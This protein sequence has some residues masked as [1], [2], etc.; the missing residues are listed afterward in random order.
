M[1]RILSLSL[2]LIMVLSC[3]AV[4]ASCVGGQT[5]TTTTK[6]LVN[7]TNHVDEDGDFLCDTEGCGMPV[8]KAGNYTYNTYMSTFPTCWNPHTYR[9]ATNGEILGYTEVGFYTFDYNETRDGFVIVP[10]MAAQ[11]PVDVTAEYVGEQWEIDEDETARAWK[12][13]LRDDLRWENGDPIKATDFVES[14]KRLLDPRYINYRA[15]SL[16]EGDMSIYGAREY[17]YGGRTIKDGS[18][19]ISADFG[20]DEYVA[21]ADLSVDENGQYYSEN[22]KIWYTVKKAGN[23]STSNSL[24]DYVNAGYCTEEVTA[25]YAELV[26]AADGDGFVPVTADTLAVIMDVIANLHGC[27]NVEAYAAEAGD[28]AY[29]EWEEACYY[30]NYFD[31]YSWDNVGILATAENEVV[32]IINDPLEG[33]YLHYSLTGNLGLVHVPTYDACIKFDELTN[34]YSN[35]YGTSVDTFMAYGP[36]KLTTFIKDKQIVLETNPHWYGYFDASRAGQFMTTKVVYDWIND[37]STAMNAFLQGK[38]DGKGLDATNIDEYRGSDRLYYT[39]GASTWFIALN[40]SEAAANTWEESHPGYDKSILSYKEFRMAL[41]QSLNRTN[42]I[43]SLDPVGSIAYGLYN[44]MICSDPDKGVMYRDEEVAKDAVLAFWGIS[45]DDIGPDGLYATKDEA[46]ESITGYN[47]EMAKVLFDQAYDKAVA[48]GFYD[49]QETVQIAIGLPGTATF[50][51]DGFELLKNCWTDAVKGTKL[52]G[53]L[54]FVADSSETV[55]N[56]FSGALHSNAIDMLFGV[57][58]KGSALNPY[59]LITAYTNPAQ[60]YD[61]NWDT[62]TATM[63]VEINGVTYRASIYDWSY[64]INGKKAEIAEVG[65]DGELTGET[66]DYSCGSAD[67]DP[68]TRLYI[69]AAIEKAVLSQYNMIPTHNQASATLLGYQLEYGSQ[70]YVYGLGRGGIQYMTY[71]YTDEAWDEYV[72]A[73][74]GI[75]NY[76]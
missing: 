36:Y 59:S 2:A 44:S 49:G 14:A 23:W 33:F 63:D 53:K 6:P 32:I 50:Y 31:E 19:M 27:E 74:G 65:E 62:T 46:I 52:E 40:P 67:K 42:F 17:F 55:Q 18:V 8:K 25:R 48:D 16:Y 72:A 58:W 4:L 69:L 26:A 30:G 45:Q 15:D 37:P 1:K 60:K 21:I 5:T 51:T 54:E 7:C 22:G 43:S 35:T 66:L 24:T 39:D 64:A 73:Q 70:E 28:Y 34:T 41:S 75:L 56:D 61:P 57:G 3:V 29:L 20:D 9:D 38:L 11:M 76:K 10:E 13:V 47:L 68:A 12:I 71:N